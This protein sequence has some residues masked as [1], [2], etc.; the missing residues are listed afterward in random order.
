MEFRSARHTDN[1]P[2]I[3]NFYTTILG[4]EL[5]FSFE[6]HN[7]YSGA[8]LGKPD[9]NWHLEF[10]SS[11]T[12]AGHTSDPEDLLVF[13]PTQKEEYDAI[14]QSIEKNSIERIAPKNAYWI[15]NGVMILDPDGFGIIVSHLKIT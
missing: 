11:S 4:L 12:K 1:L 7:S 9:H 3:V 10:T 2:S 15:E 13:Y 5:L 14:I 6:N 8:F